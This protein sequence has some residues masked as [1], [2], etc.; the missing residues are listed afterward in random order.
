MNQFVKY[1]LLSYNM[2]CFNQISITT[3]LKCKM[4][5]K[6][7]WIADNLRKRRNGRNE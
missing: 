5:N 3:E 4:L 1:S 2:F 6:D 7:V